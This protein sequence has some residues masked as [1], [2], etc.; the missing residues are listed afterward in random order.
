MVNESEFT[1][2]LN[3]KLIH[4]EYI[5]YLT[6]CLCSNNDYFA[7]RKIKTLKEFKMDLQNNDV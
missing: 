7:E 6:I 2:T 4:K 1:K 5:R 3:D